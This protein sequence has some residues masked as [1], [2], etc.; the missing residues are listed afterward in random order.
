VLSRMRPA[1]R[2]GSSSRLVHETGGDLIRY[3]ESSS[4]RKAAGCFRR[5]L[6]LLKSLDRLS[7][8]LPQLEPEVR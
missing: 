3:D 6:T 7:N 1:D 5:Q 8:P 2:A 4:K